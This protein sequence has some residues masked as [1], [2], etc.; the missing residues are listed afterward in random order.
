MN[1]RRE[2]ERDRVVERQQMAFRVTAL[3]FWPL[4]LRISDSRLPVAPPAAER[5]AR[6]LVLD[7]A[8]EAAGAVG[9]PS[10]GRDSGE[11]TDAERSSMRPVA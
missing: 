4:T 5:G 7:R 3:E 11:E 9:L 1:R 10:R 8:P 6:I 2:R